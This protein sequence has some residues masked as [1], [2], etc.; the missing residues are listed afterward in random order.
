MNSN[1]SIDGPPRFN[2]LTEACH[3][4]GIASPGHVD[5]ASIRVAVDGKSKGNRA[6]EVKRK[7][8]GYRVHNY[9]TNKTAIVVNDYSSPIKWTPTQRRKVLVAKIAREQQRDQSF[10]TVAKAAEAIWQSLPLAADNHPYLQLK[11]I[12]PHLARV[13]VATNTL[14]N[15][16]YRANGTIQSLQYIHS[17]GGKRFLPGSKVTG[18]FT[19][20]GRISTAKKFLVAEGFATGATLFEIEGLPVACALTAGNLKPVAL[21]LRAKFP[22][23]EIVIAGDND[24]LTEGNPGRTKAIEAARA[25][26]CNYTI[27][28]FPDNAPAKASDFND[29][30]Q[31]TVG[32]M[33]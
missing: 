24:R 9:V 4:I 30:Y 21:A 5:R 32:K 15:V 13:D 11:K 25:I 14:V 29:L 10:R 28:K 19:P 18:G 3:A 1:I 6:G 26:G 31:I 23:A 8:Y 20:I 22:E 17:D 7:D 2:T 27:P 12:K 16:V 33:L